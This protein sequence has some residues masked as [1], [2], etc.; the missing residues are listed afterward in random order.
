MVIGLV[1]VKKGSVGKLTKIGVR[2]S[3][4]LTPKRRE[5]LF[6]EIYSISEEIKYSCIYPKEINSAMRNGISLNE[7]EAIHIARLVDSLKSVDSVYLDS[8]DVIQE[9]FGVRV[10]LLSSKPMRVSGTKRKQS[11]DK[12]IKVIAE[13]KADALYPVVSAASIIAK[14]TRDNE[15]EDIKSSTGVDIGSGYPSDSKT[16]S[17]I[18]ENLDNLLLVPH[19]RDRW[20]TMNNIRQASIKEFF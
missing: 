16:I 9:K 11:D 17:A 20:Q 15:I 12:P 18:R 3:K 13:H 1:S 7:L 10:S 14:V 19:V 4:L 5:F 6:D 8:P 2:D